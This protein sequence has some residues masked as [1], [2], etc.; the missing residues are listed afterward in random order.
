L[1]CARPAQAWQVVDGIVAD[2]TFPLTVNSLRS[3]VEDYLAPYWWFDN[4]KLDEDAQLQ[5]YDVLFRKRSSGE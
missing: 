2:A 1:K 5:A 4:E 3:L